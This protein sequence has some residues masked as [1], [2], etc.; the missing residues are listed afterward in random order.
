MIPGCRRAGVLIA[1]GVLTIVKLGPSRR[2]ALEDAAAAAGMGAGLP[3]LDFPLLCCAH[4]TFAVSRFV[5]S[6]ASTRIAAARAQRR[7]ERLDCSLRARIR[8]LWLALI[9][10]SMMARAIARL[11]EENPK[12]TAWHIEAPGKVRLLGPA[13]KCTNANPQKEE[14]TY[15]HGVLVEMF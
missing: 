13:K 1:T 3:G 6:F 12:S 5:G 10:S 8:Q 14:R 2:I 9:A 4:R 11:P 15:T 7:D